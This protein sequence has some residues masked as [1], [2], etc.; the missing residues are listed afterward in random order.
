MDWYQIVVAAAIA[1]VATE[2]AWLVTEWEWRRITH[3]TRRH[4]TRPPTTTT[5]RKQ[6]PC[7]SMADHTRRRITPRGER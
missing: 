3:A 7:T 6:K 4:H 5:H 2:A 1:I